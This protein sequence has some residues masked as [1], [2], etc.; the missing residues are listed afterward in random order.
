MTSRGRVESFILL[1]LIYSLLRLLFGIIFHELRMTV[2]VSIRRDRLQYSMQRVELHGCL[3]RRESC[4][5][6]LHC[7]VGL[8]HKEI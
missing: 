3:R 8:R 6:G 4:W 1:R 7:A 2:D 5:G